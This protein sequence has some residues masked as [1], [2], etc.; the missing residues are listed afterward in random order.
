MVPCFSEDSLA[1]ELLDCLIQR[2]YLREEDGRGREENRARLEGLRDRLRKAY[3]RL[4]VKFSG[5]FLKNYKNVGIGMDDL[6]FQ[7]EEG[8]HEALERYIPNPVTTFPTYAYYAMKTRLNEVTAHI[9]NKREVLSDAEGEGSLGEGE[10]TS[11]AEERRILSNAKALS[12][13]LSSLSKD[14]RF[15]FVSFFGLFGHPK[16]SASQIAESLGLDRAKFR[17]FVFEAKKRL[18]WA[19][20]GKVVLRD[21]SQ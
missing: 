1:E 9:R 5:A 12:G 6:R 14:Q 21:R 7:A 10:D 8:F 3:S 13:A 11:L 17:K 18:F 20:K 2:A 15:Y 16:T 19:L 4:P